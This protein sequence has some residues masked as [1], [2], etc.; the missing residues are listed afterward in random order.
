MICLYIY[1]YNILYVICVIQTMIS[2]IR[3]NNDNDNDA[4]AVQ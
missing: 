2:K 1:I 3:S 4:L